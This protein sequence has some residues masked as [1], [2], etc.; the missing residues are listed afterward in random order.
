M[1]FKEL[2]NEPPVVWTA[3]VPMI[4]PAGGSAAWKNV[5]PVGTAPAARGCIPGRSVLRRGSIRSN[6]K[7]RACGDAHKTRSDDCTP[8]HR[9]RDSGNVNGSPKRTLGALGESGRKTDHENVTSLWSVRQAKESSFVRC[10]FRQ[11]P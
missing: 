8:A 6:R 9:D 3:M 4:V 5:L 1:A 10:M 7:V 11:G 2:E